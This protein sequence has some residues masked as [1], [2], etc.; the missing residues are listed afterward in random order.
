MCN[1]EWLS[2]LPPPV[3]QSLMELTRSLLCASRSEKRQIANW[4][5][6]ASHDTRQ[7]AAAQL[8]AREALELVAADIVTNQADTAR[9]TQ[10]EARL[11]RGVTRIR[12]ALDR[13]GNPGRQSGDN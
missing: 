11:P 4:L 1:D 13:F 8:F 7:A 12:A 5:G 2:A 6:D 10:S 3:K 9:P